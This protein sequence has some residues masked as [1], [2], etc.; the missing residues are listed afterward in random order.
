MGTIWRGGCII[1]YRRVDKDGSFHTLWAG[2][3]SEVPA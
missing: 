3:R 2:D 1:T